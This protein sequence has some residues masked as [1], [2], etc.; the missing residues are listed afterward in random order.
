MSVEPVFF[1]AVQV[2]FCFP[3]RLV[4]PEGSILAMGVHALLSSPDIAFGVA[5]LCDRRSA[6]AVHTASRSGWEMLSMCHARYYHMVGWLLNRVQ[7]IAGDDLEA[8]Q[9]IAWVDSDSEQVAEVEEGLGTHAAVCISLYE[10]YRSAL[11]RGFALEPFLR[12]LTPQLLVTALQMVA[13][14]EVQ[15]REGADM[16]FLHLLTEDVCDRLR[17]IQVGLEC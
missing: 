14:V 15:T 10:A 1:T 8:C 6:V 16:F 2:V 13:E 7:T 9:E 12:R 4:R 17:G 3:L 5:F 11:A